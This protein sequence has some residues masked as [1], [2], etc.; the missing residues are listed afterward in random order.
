MPVTWSQLLLPT[1]VF[2]FLFAVGCGCY[3]FIRRLPRMRDNFKESLKAHNM[4]F[5]EGGLKVGMKE[6]SNEEYMDSLQ[7]YAL[8]NQG[9]PDTQPS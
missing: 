5:S 4:D 6:V 8:A 2:A 7:R 1:L 3:V 9:S